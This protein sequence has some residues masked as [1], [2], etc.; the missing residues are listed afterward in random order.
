MFGTPGQPAER[1]LAEVQRMLG[2]GL[3][4]MSIYALTIEPNTQFGELHRKGR[5]PLAKEDDYADTFSAVEQLMAQHGFDHYEVSNYAKPGQ[6]SR[7]N[8]HYWHGGDYLGLGCAAVGCISDQPGRARRVRNQPNPGRYMQAESLAALASESEE[9]DGEALV[10]EALLLGLRTLAGV[11]LTHTRARAA[12]DPLL[13]RKR[14][15]ERAQALGNVVIDH[16]F[17]RV[18]QE[19]WL[20]LDSIVAD[21]F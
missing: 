2:L 21:L 11:D 4:H 15:V 8:Q 7:H 17:M 1:F 6:T 5:L 20:H 19:R 16:G 14:E 3:E 18:P 10:R 9:L 13:G 12:R